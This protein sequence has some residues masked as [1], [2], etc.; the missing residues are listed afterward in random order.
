MD[1]LDGGR[2]AWNEALLTRREALT[3]ATY[4][5]GGLALLG[6]PRPRVGTG[7][8]RA[9]PSTLV[10]SGGSPTVARTTTR[11]SGRA[12]PRSVCSGRSGVM[13]VGAT[14]DGDAV[15]WRS[16]NGQRW[17]E[18]GLAAPAPGQAEVWGVASHG[19]SFVAVGSLLQR[20]IARVIPDGAVTQ[21]QSDVTFTAARR[22]PTVWWTRDGTAWDGE[23]VDR[24]GATHAQL[25]SVS[26]NTSLLVAVGSTLDADGAQGDQGLVLVSSD[27]VTWQP[28]EIATVDAALAEGSFTG[29]AAAGDTWFAT[30]SDM[31]GGTVWSSPDGRRWAALPSSRRQFAGMTL[32]GVGVRDGRIHV[33]ATRLSDHRTGCYVSSDGCRTWRALRAASRTLA[34]ADMAINDL[35]VVDGDVVVVGTRAGAPIIEGGIA[36][37]GD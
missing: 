24:A 32:Q 34:A 29:V 30:S 1:G 22:L 28:G 3:R 37:G 4:G 8:P 2:S 23:V 11:L 25:I 21:Q 7:A 6:A 13:V 18:Q 36:D 12:Q 5:L 14:D 20:D 35:S 26:C 33:A 31:T 10:A 15:T 9:R 19:A 27:G 16:T 17:D